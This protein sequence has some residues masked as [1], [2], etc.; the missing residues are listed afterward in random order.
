MFGKLQTVSFAHLGGDV[1]VYADD[2]IGVFDIE[3][4]TVNPAVNKFL[5]LTQKSGGIYYCSQDLTSMPKSF[6][7]ADE[8]VY[9]SNVAAGTI[10]KR[11]NNIC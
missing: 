6:T 9:V 4:T 7:L 8:T 3:R 2:I 5:A 1:S 11:A 10:R